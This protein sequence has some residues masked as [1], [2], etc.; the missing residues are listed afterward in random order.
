MNSSPQDEIL[1]ET[2]TRKA[3]DSML[4][5]DAQ[6]SEKKEAETLTTCS[7][8]P[9]PKGKRDQPPEDIPRDI[10]IPIDL[11]PPP[12][13]GMARQIQ[14]VTPLTP[15][16]P[17]DFGAPDVTNPFSSMLEEEKAEQRMRGS[18][19]I[20]DTD[21][22]VLYQSKKETMILERI[23]PYKQDFLQGKN[24]LSILPRWTTGTLREYP[25]E[26]HYVEA[27]H[28][29]L[30]S[31]GEHPDLVDEKVTMMEGKVLVAEVRQREALY[32]EIY[33][34]LYRGHK[35]QIMGPKQR[36]KGRLLITFNQKE[37]DSP[38]FNT[39][40]VPKNS[41]SR[42]RELI[43]LMHRL[44]HSSK[45]CVRT[46]PNRALSKD[47]I[48]HEGW[49]QH[50]RLGHTTLH[51]GL[52]QSTDRPRGYPCEGPDSMI[53]GDEQSKPRMNRDF[54]PKIADMKGRP[55]RYPVESS[56][57]ICLYKNNKKKAL[58]EQR[59]EIRFDQGA[60]KVKF[61]RTHHH[62]L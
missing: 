9:I 34:E 41:M 1:P 58:R 16:R 26:V 59:R 32:P 35:Q 47:W 37:D 21:E 30:M 48:F 54:I 50:G 10:L 61:P 60:T 55:A 14:M 20:I 40:I 3:K 44:C 29:L 7:L 27:P 39:N 56:T 8:S 38:K 33:T 53:T 6:E 45:R 51:V 31:P 12:S 11:I 19:P 42:E 36:K 17:Y 57:R 62:K 52:G 49:K 18:S 22:P 24:K 23:G 2:E 25:S 13:V 4:N 15:A 5:P 43:P 28:A 46:P